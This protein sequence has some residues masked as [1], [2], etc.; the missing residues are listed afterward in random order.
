MMEEEG[1]ASDHEETSLRDINRKWE[2]E[3]GKDVK[4]RSAIKVRFGDVKVYNVIAWGHAYRQARCGPWE[5]QAR[6]RERFKRRVKN[7]E[8][9]LSRVLDPHHR[10]RAAPLTDAQI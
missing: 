9:L 1:N 8:P 10:R 3:V 6:D 4:G 2:E 5:E 7:L